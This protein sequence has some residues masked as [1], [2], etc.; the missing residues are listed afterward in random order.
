M[1]AFGKELCK[2]PLGCLEDEISFLTVRLTKTIL[3][4]KG[5]E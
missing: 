4:T 1:A 5:S 3:N 2:T